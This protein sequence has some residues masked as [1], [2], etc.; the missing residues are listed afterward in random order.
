MPWVK[1]S[2]LLPCQLIAYPPS[3]SGLRSGL[4]GSTAQKLV[5]YRITLVIVGDIV[6]YL[7]A[8]NALRDWV[9]ESNR[10]GDLWFVPDD[11]TL[12]ARLVA[13]PPE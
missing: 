6:A 4:A 2:R 9:R 12:A 8:S 1:G 13:R 5:N 7:D 10:N 11:G 3:S